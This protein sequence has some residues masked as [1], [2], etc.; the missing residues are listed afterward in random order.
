MNDSHVTLQGWVGGPVDV[1]DVAGTTCASFRIGCTPRYLRAGQWVDGETSWFT[2]NC[3]RALGE[4][5]RHS[6]NKGDPVIVQGRIRT[7]VW[8]REGEPPQTTIFVDAL[9]VG[10]DLTRGTS[11]FNKTTRPVVATV[12][13][14]QVKEM[15]HGYS[16]DGPKLNNEGE[17][18]ETAA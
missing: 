7:D 6:I 3:W 18:V 11:L 9:T 16:A 1:R 8:R 17:P 10:H 15:L 12:E 5:V 2:I 14:E 4:N 13:D